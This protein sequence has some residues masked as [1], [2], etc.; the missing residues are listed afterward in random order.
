MAHVA[1]YKKDVVKKLTDLMS[2]YP[3]VG[4]VDL[5][6][7][8]APPL[9]KMKSQLR[10]KVEIFM[11]KKRLI[12]L[13]LEKAKETKPGLEKL[14]EYFRGMPAL[15]F[16]NDNPFSLFKTLK[17]SKSPAPIK[18]G[19]TAPKEIV[20][21]SGPTGFAPGPIISELGSVGIKCGVVDGKV[22]IKEDSVVAKEGDKVDQNLA[23][24][25]TRLGIEPMEVGLNIVAVFEDKVIYDQKTLD[26]DEEKF[27]QDLSKAASW[28][29]NLAFEAAYPTKDTINLLLGKAFQDSKAI[30][31]EA[32]IIDQ[33][34]IDDL[35]GKAERSMQSLKSTANIDTPKAEEK[36]EEPKQEVKGE[37]KAEE[38]PAEPKVEEKPAEAPKLEEKP[39]EEAKPKIPKESTEEKK[40]K[41]IEKETEILKEEE[42]VEKEAA[43]KEKVESEA[44]KE[45][46]EGI[47]EEVE[48]DLEKERIEQEKKIQE[49][50]KDTD[51]KV[52]EMVKKTK[53]HA[54]GKQPTTEKLLEETEVPKKEEKPEPK[55][56]EKVP[57]A[58]ELADKKKVEEQKKALGI[59]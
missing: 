54:A 32:N 13:A 47:K 4:L 40:E 33:G 16:T 30:G 9:Q 19:Q 25:L 48:K 59:S 3:I 49:V 7:L 36:K 56:E 12:R 42:K 50:E 29:F 18:A 53:E 44:E 22:A 14:E 51:S 34:I 24:I 26:I 17:K 39:K 37:P 43:E 35:L 23:G 11:T 21:K 58:A 31:L 55:V 6:N 8:P 46:E 38:K 20:I 52:A 5:E 15:I 28:A 45:V 27:N 1:Q 10:G 57:T 2:K 41:A